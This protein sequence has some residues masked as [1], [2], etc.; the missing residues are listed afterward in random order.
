MYSGVATGIFAIRNAGK[1]NN[2]DLGRL[3]VTVVQTASVV[4]AGSQYNNIFTKPAQKVMKTFDE[5]AKSDKVFNGMSKIV[6]FASDHV[7][8]LIVGSSIIKVFA[9]DDKQS[10]FISESGNILGMILGEGWMKVHLDGVLAKANIKGKWAPV[11]RGLA[12]V[13][14][15]ITASSIGQKIGDVAALSLKKSNEKEKLEEQQIHNNIP[16]SI[17]LKA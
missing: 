5:M 8:H 3:P 15:S 1:T 10:T 11:I 17:S 4:K 9:S 16:K 7:N 6:K 13:A 2:G 14:G 12:F